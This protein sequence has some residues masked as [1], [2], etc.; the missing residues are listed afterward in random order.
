MTQLERKARLVADHVAGD[1]DRDSNFPRVNV[2]RFNHVAI[3]HGDRRLPFAVNRLHDHR[4]F[5]ARDAKE[6]FYS[7]LLVSYN[8]PTA[9]E[10]RPS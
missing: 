9:S 3:R 2:F 8:A 7:F 1:A 4:C 5:P 6:L 10:C